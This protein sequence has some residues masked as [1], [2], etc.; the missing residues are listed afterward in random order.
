MTRASK[1]KNWK[2]MK[3][4]VS[5]LYENSKKHP[6]KLALI[7]GKK[8]ITYKEMMYRVKQCAAILK[9]TGIN[10]KDRV[11]VFVP[12]SLDLYILLLGLWYIGATAVFLDAWADKKRLSQAAA[13]A[14]CKA[15]IG[16]TKA[17]LLRLFSKKIR[18]IPIHL[19]AHTCFQYSKKINKD[20]ITT[21][22]SDSDALV[23]FTTGSTGVPKAAKRTHN[24]LL[25]QH[26]V[27]TQ[28][29]KPDLEDRDMV[30]LPIFLLSNL[31]VGITSVIAPFNP[32]KPHLLNP[33][34]VIHLIEK[35]KI[36][37]TAGSP[38]IYTQCAD[39]C[40]KN[41]I[42]LSSLKK[43]FLGGAPVF[44][45]TA[46]KLSDAFP[47]SYVEIIYGSTEAEPISTIRAK[48][49]V[50]WNKFISTEGLLVGKPISKIALSIL[51]I[52]DNPISPLSKNAFNALCL[53]SGEVGEICVSG[54]HVL[55]KYFRNSEAFKE[56]KIKVEDTLW[57]R[58]GDAGYCNKNGDLFLMGRVKQHFFHRNQQ[59]F[60]FPLEH[61]LMQIPGVL[62][63]TYIKKSNNLF[64]II[65]KIKKDLSEKYILEYLN[66]NQMPIPDSIIFKAIPR[67]PRHRSKIDYGLLNHKLNIL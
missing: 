33:K 18:S 16:I 29:L 60:V 2:I 4:I 67:D 10:S 57:H 44:P 3:N 15:F 64:V 30:T 37:S 19:F 11:F 48:E 8:R 52:Q 56:N 14:D 31:A 34:K 38:I 26:E 65:E 21:I 55:K 51:P 23:T 41:S 53:K 59:Y 61:K 36:T 5:I 46:Q 63:G 47:D 32:A 66:N 35:Y 22:S 24:F 45:G 17:H 50:Q 20:P 58:T 54:A 12:M 40:L 6:E 27:L 39:Y 42:Q 9:G 43:I 28:H 49:L 25:A 7:D 62:L 1:R 13:L